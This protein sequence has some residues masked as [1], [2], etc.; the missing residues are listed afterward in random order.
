MVRWCLEIAWFNS[1]CAIRCMVPPC[2]SPSATDLRERQR[3]QTSCAVTAKAGSMERYGERGGG[4]VFAL[5]RRS[6][7]ISPHHSACCS[8]ALG[9][10]GVLR[11][12]RRGIC[13]SLGP[14]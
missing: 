12:V 9:K 14:T 4:G 2:L 3:G 6:R 5:L 11:A 7:C 13:R 8:R 10:G 1:T